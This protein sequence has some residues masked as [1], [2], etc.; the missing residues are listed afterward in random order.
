MADII[1]AKDLRPGMTYLDKGNI[2]LV[3]E[4]TFNKTSMA[5]AVIKCRVKNLRT[6]YT[7][8]ETLSEDK[9]EKAEIITVPMA[10]TYVDGNNY[11]F[12]DNTT[13]ETIEIPAS[14]LEWEKNFI[15]EGLNIKVRKYGEEILDIALP[16]QIK[17]QVKEAEEAVQGNSVTNASKKAWLT[18][19]WEIEVPQF[20]KTGEY[21]MIN[22]IDGKYVCRA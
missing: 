4:N 1:H 16:D 2:F 10:F 3:I 22:T 6:G 15:T 8:W 13:Y 5:K 19:G 7:L 9:Y 11:V 14:K 20:I 17:M 12:M 18:T 21:V